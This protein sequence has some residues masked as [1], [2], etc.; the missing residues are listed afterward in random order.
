MRTPEMRRRMAAEIVDYE[1]RRDANRHL[2]VYNLPEGDGGG[3]Y[4]V[5]GIEQSRVRKCFRGVFGV[6][7]IVAGWTG[8]ILR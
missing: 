8:C 7:T 5:A 1:A 2:K 6:V 4:E 3:R